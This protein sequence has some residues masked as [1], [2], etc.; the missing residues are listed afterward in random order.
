MNEETPAVIDG[1]PSGHADQEKPDSQVPDVPVETPTG[2]VQTDSKDAKHEGAPE[3]YEFKLPE[4]IT[5]DQAVTD[6]FTSLAKEMNLPNDKAQAYLDLAIEHVQGI[7]KA[8]A[9]AWVKQ[10]SGWA[11]EVKADKELGGQSFDATASVAASAVERFGSPELKA[12]LGMPSPE[13]PNGMGLGNHP[14]LV[15]FCARIG[16]AMAEDGHVKATSSNGINPQEERLRNLYD[17][18]NMS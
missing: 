1:Q 12:L 4:G 5:L 17:K 11:E 8:Q 14:E 18:S 13:N 15:R 7:Q 3:N 10:V 2:E 9:D 6:K 16:K